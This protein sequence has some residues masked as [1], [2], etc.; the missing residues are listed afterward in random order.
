MTVPKFI[1]CRFTVHL[2]LFSQRIY[3]IWRSG[4]KC[5]CFVT[6]A[7]PLEEHRQISRLTSLC[8]ILNKHVAVPGPGSV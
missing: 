3:L 1:N 2:I 5:Y 6:A 7:S 8:K 4:Y